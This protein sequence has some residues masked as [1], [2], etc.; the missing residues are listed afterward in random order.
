MLTNLCISLVR[1][2]R[3]KEYVYN[4]APETLNIDGQ[5]I[6]TLH[7]TPVK[8]DKKKSKEFWLAKKYHY[9]PVYIV[10]IDKRGQKLEQTLLS[11]E[12]K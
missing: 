5:D 11:F 4:V 6:E 3:H 2:N 12:A 7:L 10:V 9:L 8:K 1:L